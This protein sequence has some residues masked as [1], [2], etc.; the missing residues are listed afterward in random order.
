MIKNILVAID[1][2]DHSL[3]AL[4]LACTIA[5]KHDAALVL[6]HVLKSEVLP[7]D[8]LRFAELEHI[9][10]P[11]REILHH[12][13]NRILE[14]ASEKAAQNGIDKIRT[15]LEEG[16]TARTIVAYAKDNDVDMIV[17]GS[18]GLGEI[19]GA[20]LGSVSHK[21]NSLAPCTC[22]TVR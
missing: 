15:A 4:D 12:L 2:S 10:G 22:I 7:E 9:P 14:S 18:R 6:L 20:L 16:P 11:P 21:V 3:R 17:M 5:S 13:A 8:L 19:E 1:G